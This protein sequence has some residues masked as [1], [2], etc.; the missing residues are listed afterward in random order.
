[1]RPLKKEKGEE[2]R[3]KDRQERKSMHMSYQD[4]NSLF[5]IF[6]EGCR[7]SL[8]GKSTDCSSKGPEFKS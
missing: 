5:K 6:F 1:V 7:D 3:K 2:E 8:A 4:N